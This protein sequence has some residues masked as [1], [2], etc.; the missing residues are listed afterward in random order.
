MQTEAILN[1]AGLLWTHLFSHLFTELD[2]ALNRSPF[3]ETKGLE[4]LSKVT[5]SSGLLVPF[6]CLHFLEVERKKNFKPSNKPEE[7]K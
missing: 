2:G 1:P 4:S 5:Q 6:L 7:T 3:I